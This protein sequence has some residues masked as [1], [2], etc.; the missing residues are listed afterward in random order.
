MTLHLMS[1]QVDLSRYIL[2]PLCYIHFSNATG[3]LIWW[4]LVYFSQQRRLAVHKAI[5]FVTLPLCL[6]HLKGSSPTTIWVVIPMSPGVLFNSHRLSSLRPYNHQNPVK[7]ISLA[8]RLSA[9]FLN[10]TLWV[11]P[12][13]LYLY[14]SAIK[15]WGVLTAYS[16]LYHI[17]HHTDHVHCFL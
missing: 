9:H 3:L 4:S 12:M 5:L 6:Q 2:V 17:H 16:S 1:S 13:Q 11:K 10:M 7:K 15:E 14:L 8:I